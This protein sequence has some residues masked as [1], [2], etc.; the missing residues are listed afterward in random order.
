MHPGN[1][2]D[3]SLVRL[4]VVRIRKLLSG[5]MRNAGEDAMG[6]YDREYYRREGPSF[7]ASFSERGQMCKWLIGINVIVFVLQLLTKQDLPNTGPV[8][9]AFVLNA[10]KVV[11]EGQIWRLLTYA[12]LHDT[13][14]VMHILFN[15]LFLWWFGSDI[16]DL[17]GPK[18]FVLFYLAAAVAGGVFFTL[19]WLAGVG[20]ALCL[21]AS[22]AVTAVLLLA[23]IH[24]PGRIIL[25]F[26]VLPIPIWLFVL[27]NVAMD[28]F[29]FSNNL[30]EHGDTTHVAVAV[31]LAGAAFA[32]VYYKGH[33][34]ILGL[35]QQVR[36]WQRGA[37]RPRL[38]VYREEP[39]QR[40]PVAAV[41][42]E[43]NSDEQ[44]E[45]K[46]DAI[47]EKVARQG[48]AS[49]TESENQI[50]MRAS[51]VYKRRRS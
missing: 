43:V 14:N 6:I 49:L 1:S 40:V 42:S 17:Y 34:R 51:E 36:G 4:H 11:S 32:Y 18:E 21:G 2:G 22:G 35:W 7:L 20:G 37:F 46:L 39:V 28:L 10:D 41:P 29:H 26:F 25:L 31:H 5:L 47:L 38:R 27:F 16:E 8:T 48:R 33:W 24:F 15:M 3:D 50:L 23:A 9:D 44:L 45:A 19:A 13:A 30:R 12:F